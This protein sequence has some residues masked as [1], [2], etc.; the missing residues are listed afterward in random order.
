MHGFKSVPN[1]FCIASFR[2]KV[3]GIVATSQSRLQCDGDS[4]CS[5][6]FFKGGGCSK[7]DKDILGETTYI[8]LLYAWVQVQASLFLR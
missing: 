2:Q 8:V 5:S 3:I 4:K 7:F 6:L 1:Y